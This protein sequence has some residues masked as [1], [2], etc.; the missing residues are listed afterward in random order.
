[1]T[2]VQL[3]PSEIVWAHHVVAPWGGWLL[4]G[5]VLTLGLRWFFR[6]LRRAG[7]SIRRTTNDWFGQR[8]MAKAQA[9]RHQETQA[10]FENCATPGLIE[11]SPGS[12]MK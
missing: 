6:T 7:R 11:P 4:G 5:L 3:I 1:M 9:V 8:K 10:L 12:R 2:I